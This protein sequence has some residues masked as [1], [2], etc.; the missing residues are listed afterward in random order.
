MIG[1]V[2]RLA[3]EVAE[4]EQIDLPEDFDSDTRLFGDTGLLDSLGLVSLV[5]SVEE[6]IE[7]LTGVSVALADERAMSQTRSPFRTV[8]SLSEYATA[9]SEESVAG[10]H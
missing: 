7:D 4:S 9:L 5:L 2:L 8:R 1:L 10:S 3:R 6:A